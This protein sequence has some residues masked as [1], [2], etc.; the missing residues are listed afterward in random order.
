MP[1]ARHASAKSKSL[2]CPSQHGCDTAFAWA[3]AVKARQRINRCSGNGRH[4]TPDERLDTC[5]IKKPCRGLRPV[6]QPRRGSR[7]VTSGNEKNPMRTEG[8]QPDQQEHHVIGKDKRQTG[9]NAP[10]VF[11]G[12]TWDRTRHPLIMSQML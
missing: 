7:S 10:S 5:Q 6:T 2:E 4:Q 9:Q 1:D 3:T 8:A 11:R 12:P